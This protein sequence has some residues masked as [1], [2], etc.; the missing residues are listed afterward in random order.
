MLRNHLLYSAPTYE[1]FII[2]Y[3]RSVYPENGDVIAGRAAI[4]VSRANVD[5]ATEQCRNDVT[6]DGVVSSLSNDRV[7]QRHAEF[8]AQRDISVTCDHQCVVVAD[9]IT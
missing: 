1:R 5:S 3:T 2:T 8:V 7:Q 4:I 6:F 9:V